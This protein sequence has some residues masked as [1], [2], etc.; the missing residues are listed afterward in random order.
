M[1][2]RTALVKADFD[3]GKKALVEMIEFILDMA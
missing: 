3:L 1:D 2:L